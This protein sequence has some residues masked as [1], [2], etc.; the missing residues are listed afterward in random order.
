[1]VLYLMGTTG[2]PNPESVGEVSRYV[3]MTLDPTAF[4]S[5]QIPGWAQG[6]PRSP[7]VSP[8]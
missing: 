6:V 1:M 4:G 7:I 5:L 2:T 8:K 3:A